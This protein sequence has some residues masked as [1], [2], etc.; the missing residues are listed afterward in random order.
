MQRRYDLAYYLFASVVVLALTLLM[1]CVDALA[2]IAFSSNRTG[3]FEI[4]VKVK[5]FR[6]ASGNRRTD[7]VVT[8]D[9]SQN[10]TA[11][12]QQACN[13]RWKIEQFHRETKQVTGI[14]G[15]QCRLARIVRNH[16]GCAMLVWVRLKTIAYQT[17]QTIYQVKNGLFSQY[18]T[19]QLKTPDIHMK[20]A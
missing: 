9:L 7:Y 17:D 5:L 20:L 10:D 2:Q 18:L 8:N 15:C 6:V 14:E 11:V 13:Q 12:A 3:N 16:I 1:V 19:Q 4:Y